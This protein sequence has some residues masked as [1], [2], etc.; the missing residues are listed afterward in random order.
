MTELPFDAVLV[1]NRGEIAVRVLT[2]A[3]EAGLR[4][5]AVFSDADAKALH[6][7]LADEAIHLPGQTLAETYLNTDAIIAAAQSSGAQAIH[8]GYGFLSERAD[9]ASAVKQAGLIWIGP[10]PEAISTMGDKISARLKMME[11]GVPVI[12]GEELS[13]PDGADHLGQLAACAA[14]VGY[15]LLL[16]A[17]AG[18]GGKGMRAVSEP[19]MLRTE[20]EA[21]SR[22]ASAAF[23]DGTIY[24]ERLLVG[25]RHIEVQVLADSHGNCIHLNERDCSLQRRHQKVIE[26][27]PSPVV[28]A[29]LREAMGAAAVMA[30]KAV[31]YEGAGTVEFLLSDRGD[32]F[33]L[34]MNTRL[35]VEHPV[36]E[37]ITGVDLVLKQ[38]EVAAGM[39]LGLTQSDIGITGHSMEARIYAE[40]PSK[41]FLPAIGDLAMWRAPAGPGI[42]VDTGVREGDSVTVDFDPMLAKLVVHAPTRTAAARRLYNA[43]SDLRALGVIT[44]IGFLRQMTIHPDFVS[45]SI[46]TDYLDSTDISEFAEPEHDPSTLVAIAAAASRFGLDRVGVAG[47]DGTLVDEHT[48]HAG[49]PFRTL[50]RSFP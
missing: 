12:P 24:V 39:T 49:D 30:A 20:Y 41:G 33:F 43:L 32:F 11:S 25:A 27:A 36:T 10:P 28:N 7:E 23:G 4:G 9:F 45:G 40:D 17:S 2:A 6:V 15:P 47:G 5:V 44:N 13:V 34:E 21:A 1:A 38:F 16:K 19:K 35:Q 3:R 14:R 18:G 48:G 8:P 50:S 22:E 42:R 29:E 31:D 37:M 26:E 46:T